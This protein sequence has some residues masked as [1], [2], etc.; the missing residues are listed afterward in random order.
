MAS[1]FQVYQP[2]CKAFA[3]FKGSINCA[4]KAT[5]KKNLRKV[6]KKKGEKIMMHSVL[7]V[8]KNVSPKMILPKL[9][10]MHFT[11]QI[12]IFRFARN[13]QIGQFF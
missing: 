2:L 1:T 7:K 8:T 10:K 5:P 3:A 9:G 4:A 13:D 11:V 12:Q 6:N